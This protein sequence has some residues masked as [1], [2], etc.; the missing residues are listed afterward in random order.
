MTQI[1][2]V[3][4]LSLILNFIQNHPFCH[5]QDILDHLSNRDHFTTERTMQRDL[6]TIR[7]MCFIEIKYSRTQ[8]GYFI[9]KDSELD[10]KE[11]IQLFEV[12]SRANVISQILLKTAG[13][14]EFIDFDTPVFNSQEQLFPDLLKAIIE[15]RKIEFRYLR[16][17]EEKT[18][19]ITL[20]P[21]LLKEYLN[22]WYVVGTN[23]EGEFRSYGLERIEKFEIT[24]NTFRPKV[25]N[26]KGLFSEVIGLY[27]EN[28]REKVILSY[29]VFQGK[30]IKSQP[31]HPTQKI[32]IDDENELRIELYVRPNYELEEQILKQGERVQV[33]EP[34]WLREVIKERIRNSF[35]NYDKK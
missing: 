30:Y 5:L 18:E 7:E 32:L 16:Y 4:R 21:Q 25:K 17:W 14:I 3:E 33:M 29:Q 9:D 20:E 28:E 8:N 10:F 1:K 26:P 22:R 31:L 24:A 12:F 11:W 13:S 19:T 6:K 35:L 2:S 34:K 15:K 27:S 23:S